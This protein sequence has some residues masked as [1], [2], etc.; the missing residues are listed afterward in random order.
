[1]LIELRMQKIISTCLVAVPVLAGR[2]PRPEPQPHYTV[3][4]PEDAAKEITTLRNGIV[5]QLGENE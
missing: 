5:R 1:M 3:A 4:C 2:A